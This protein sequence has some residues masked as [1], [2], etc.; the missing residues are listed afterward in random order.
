MKQNVKY[1]VVHSTRTMPGE[2]H[3]AGL[4]HYV[5]DKTGKA[6]REKIL[7]EKDTCLQVAYTG[8]LNSEG[9]TADTRNEKQKERLFNQ[10][11]LLSEKYPEAKIIGAEELLSEEQYPGFDV[12]K[13]LSEYVPDVLLAA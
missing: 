11:V 12:K 5:I 13:W 6:I 10:L 1:I 4:F 9:K 3:T 8:G 2:K 7:A